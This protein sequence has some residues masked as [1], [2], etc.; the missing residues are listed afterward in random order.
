[1]PK[2]LLFTK[3]KQ[4]MRNLS[5]LVIL[6]G[7]SC[8]NSDSVQSDSTKCYTVEYLH[9]SGEQRLATLGL[10]DLEKERLHAASDEGSYYLTTA[11]F[12]SIVYNSEIVVQGATAILAVWPC[13]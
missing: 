11:E 3:N 8:S 7:Y 4:T 6:L 13:K 1:M 12:G 10:T 5:F 9:I 2:I